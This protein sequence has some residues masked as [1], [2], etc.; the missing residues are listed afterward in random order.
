MTV[1]V[2]NTHLLVVETP[3]KCLSG[4]PGAAYQS[5]RAVRGEDVFPVASPQ[6]QTCPSLTPPGLDSS[7]DE[8]CTWTR[9]TP[10]DLIYSSSLL[11]FLHGLLDMSCPTLTPDPLVDV[12]NRTESI[13][14]PLLTK[15]HPAL[16]ISATSK[17]SQGN[18]PLGPRTWASELPSQYSLTESRDLIGS[19]Q[20]G[21]PSRE[22][23]CLTALGHGCLDNTQAGLTELSPLRS[24]PRAT[25]LGHG[26]LDNTLAGLT[27]LSP[28]RSSPRY[29][30]KQIFSCGE[31]EFQLWRNRVSAVEN[32]IRRDRESPNVE[33]QERL[34]VQILHCLAPVGQRMASTLGKRGQWFCI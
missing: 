20:P 28:L 13:S 22:R 25:A 12:V 9:R 6:S 26:C 31:T 3:E 17:L 19:S 34:A 30:E 10:T 11:L 16:Q 24:S 33:V 8:G 15:S 23:S 32:T 21:R 2:N 18:A 27:E 14:S 4:V 5:M 1:K 7:S 29:P